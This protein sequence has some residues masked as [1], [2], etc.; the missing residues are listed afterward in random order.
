VSSTDGSG[1]VTWGMAV[2]SALLGVLCIILVGHVYMLHKLTK[3]IAGALGKK[4][5]VLDDLGSYGRLREY[6]A[7]RQQTSSVVCQQTS[8]KYVDVDVHVAPPSSLA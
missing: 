2:I 6:P 1:S 5:V 7:V 4:S 3:S 8:D